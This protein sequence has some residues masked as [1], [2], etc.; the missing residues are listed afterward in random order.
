MWDAEQRTPRERE[1]VDDFLSAIVG[2]GHAA[3][4]AEGLDPTLA[5]AVRAVAALAEAPP[6]TA[7]FARRLREDLMRQAE[8][9][10][11]SVS[12]PSL[13]AANNGSRL[14]PR[15]GRPLAPAGAYPLTRQPRPALANWATAALLLL[16]LGFGIAAL[17]VS[18]SGGARPRLALYAGTPA[19]TLTSTPLLRLTLSAAWTRNINW[20]GITRAAYTPGGYSREDSVGSSQLYFV[21][22][23][24]FIARS[25]AGS[26]P[27][28]ITAGGAP[29]PAASPSATT[30]LRLAAGDGLL[31]PVGSTIDL[32]NDGRSPASILW[33]MGSFVNDT[34]ESN[35]MASTDADV[36]TVNYP[37]SGIVP[38]PPVAVA[39][40]RVALPPGEA[41]PN[42]P[43]GSTVAIGGV[44]PTAPKHGAALTAEGR[45]SAR[46]T[47]STS[48]DAYVLTIAPLGTATPA[49]SP[50]P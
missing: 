11:A 42:P 17:R 13:R 40:D 10:A 47:G 18:P 33:L 49:A 15:R 48:L 8:C 9:A 34:P 26:P 24:S 12:H 16:T 25:V 3:L 4:P 36:V 21:E 7:E 5:D 29:E 43:A 19:A 1:R 35:G 27:I 50:A 20:V 41:L 22:T 30:D 2:E 45:G 39:F 23:G 37:A 6:P 31:L 44:D 14:A 38:R 28:R 32:R 46:N